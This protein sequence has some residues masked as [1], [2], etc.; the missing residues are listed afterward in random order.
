MFPVSCYLFPVP[1]THPDINLRSVVGPALEYLRGRVGRGPAPGRQAPR[2]LVEVREAKV[3]DLISKVQLFFWP[4]L[5]QFPCSFNKR[6]KII[7]IIIIRR[8][9]AILN[10]V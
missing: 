4:Q 7:I 9:D 1:D 6:T 3:R 8:L 10:T 2:R 5:F